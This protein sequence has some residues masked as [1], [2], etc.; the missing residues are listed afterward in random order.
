MRMA[1]IL[2]GSQL[3][4]YLE[5][6]ATIVVQD[7]PE[8]IGEAEGDGIAVVAANG[9]IV[10][11]GT[12]GEQMTVY[13][14]MDRM[15]TILTATGNEVSVTVPASGVYMVRIEERPARKV[16]VLR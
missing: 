7:E 9:R 16:V 6:F 15:V 5:R 4:A 2:P 10:V 14:A 11:R 12:A 8:G 3:D 1:D 13:D